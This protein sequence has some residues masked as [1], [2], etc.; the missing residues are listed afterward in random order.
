[1]Q[2]ILITGGAGF[3][4]SHFT[5]RLLAEGCRVTILDDLST[6]S[7]ENLE[8]ALGDPRLDFIEGTILDP[9]LVRRLVASNDVVIHLAAAVGV[10]Y[11]LDNPLSTIKTNVRGTDI[12]LEAAANASVKVLLA[13]TSEVYGKNEADSLCEDADSVLGP[14]SKSRWSYATGKK[15]DEFLALAYARTARLPVVILR[16]FNIA[17]PRQAGRYGMVLPNFIRAAAADEPLRV[18]GD[19]WQTRNFT[20]VEDCVEA[21]WRLLSCPAAEGETVNIGGSEEI[22][23][24]DLARRVIEVTGSA[25]PIVSVPYEQAYPGGDFEDMRRRVPCICKIE[26]L[27]GWSAATPLDEMI[28][29]TARYERQKVHAEARRLLL[30]QGPLPVLQR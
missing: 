30:P 20:Y 16:F 23:I 24:F 13:S 8:I 29:A 11:I 22:A 6:G 25:S 12:L 9:P 19:G 17:G 26:R 21:L 10:R 28:R 18:F 14:A 3:I 1:M 27:V 2:R 5:E 7:L 15:L 4:G